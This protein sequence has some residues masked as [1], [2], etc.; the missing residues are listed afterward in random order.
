MA[1][2]GRVRV[3]G[4][5]IIAVSISDMAAQDERKARQRPVPLTTSSISSHAFSAA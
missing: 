2:G 4:P 1:S 3:G 5:R